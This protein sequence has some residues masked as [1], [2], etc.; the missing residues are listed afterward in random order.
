[1]SLLSEVAPLIS[2]L[3]PVETGVFS[4]K[5]PERYAVLIPLLDRFPLYGDDL[6][7]T[8]IQEVRISLFSKENYLSLQKQIVKSLLRAGITITDRRYLGFE[9]ESGYHHYAIDIAKNYEW[10]V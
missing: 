9:P 6:P 7:S 1:M 10:E 8:E 3:I 4:G 2:P 5:A